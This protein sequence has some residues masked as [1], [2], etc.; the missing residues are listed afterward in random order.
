MDHQLL[1]VPEPD[2][3]PLRQRIAVGLR[4]MAPSIGI[5]STDL[6]H[7]LGE[8]PGLIWRDNL[9]PHER[10]CQPAR[11]ARR[12]ASTQVFIVDEALGVHLRTALQLFCRDGCQLRRHP[13]GARTEITLAS[14]QTGPK[15]I[16]TIVSPY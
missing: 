2:R 7:L 6:V 8:H 5:D 3:I 12:P 1:P 15:A 11:K 9:L 10:L 4:R 13:S 14:A 16:R